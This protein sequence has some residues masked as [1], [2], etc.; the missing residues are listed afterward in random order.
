VKYQHL[1]RICRRDPGARK[2][3]IQKVVALRHRHHHLTAV[4]LQVHRQNTG[5]RVM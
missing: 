4:G 3:E 2:G 1:M 5:H